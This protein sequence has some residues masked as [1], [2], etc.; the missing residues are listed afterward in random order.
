M[1]EE[2]WELEGG[3]PRPVFSPANPVVNGTVYVYR[4]RADGVI[5]LATCRLDDLL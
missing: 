1:S 2:L 4:C 3:V 5:G